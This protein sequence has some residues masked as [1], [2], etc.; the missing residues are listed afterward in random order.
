MMAEAGRPPEILLVT[1]HS[2][3]DARLALR[4]H[5]EARGCPDGLFCFNDDV[6]LGASRAIRE[7][8]LRVPEDVALIGHD[9]I[10]DAEYLDCPLTTLVQPVQ[11]MTALAWRFLRRRMDDPTLPPQQALLKTQLVVRASTQRG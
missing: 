10:E 9:G 5:I 7:N 8:G 2:R 1:H 11:E 3:A 4:K 6:A